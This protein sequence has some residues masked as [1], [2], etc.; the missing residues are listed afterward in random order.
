MGNIG[1][2]ADVQGLNFLTVQP[3]SMKA[4]SYASTFSNHNNHCY[5]HTAP[6]FAIFQVLNRHQL[7]RWF[8]SLRM[9][10]IVQ[11]EMVNAES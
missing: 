8:E 4:G 1:D 6:L 5:I 11:M 2:L 10:K 9:I 7:C 3:S